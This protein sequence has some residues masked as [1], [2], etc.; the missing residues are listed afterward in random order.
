MHLL[1]MSSLRIGEKHFFHDAYRTK[2]V[3]TSTNREQA[4]CEQAVE[5]IYQNFLKKKS[6]FGSK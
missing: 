1:D 4:E 3:N 5:R 6:S 2:D